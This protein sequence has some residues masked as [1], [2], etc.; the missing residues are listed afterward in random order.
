MRGRCQVM[1]CSGLE[2]AVALDRLQQRRKKFG[3]KLMSAPDD[4]PAGRKRKPGSVRGL[5]ALGRER[6]SRHFF[7]RD[8]LYSEIGNFFQIQNIPDDPNLAL[9]T[10]R[11]LASELLDP[12]VETFGPIAVRSA[13]RSPAVNGYGA[14]HNLGCA[15]NEANRAGHIWDQRDPDGNCG[16]C[17]S[18]VIPWF[19]DQYEKG[20][21][22]QDLAWWLYDH[23]DFHAIFFF[24]KRA[25]FN[26][27]WRENPERRISSWIGP[28]RVIL[29][30]GDA[31]PPI[32]E[33]QGRYTDFPPFRGVQYPELPQRYR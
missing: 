17:T 28:D 20:R 13:Y 10:G 12:L 16:A 24:P 15:S 14:E 25:A 6:L 22:W 8:F 9:Y 21:D 11:K 32:E 30:P 1:S 4:L 3:T 2:P 29:R 31:L 18:V 26:L 33:R 23:L 19:A 27:T 7:M 5:E